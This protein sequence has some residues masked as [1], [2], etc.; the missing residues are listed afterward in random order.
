MPAALL[1][2]DDLDTHAFR[3]ATTRVYAVRQ[4]V[5]LLKLIGG[6]FWGESPEIRAFISLPPYG[7][8][9]GTRRTEA[10]VARPARTPREPSPRL[11]P[12]GRR[13][14]ER[15]RAVTRATLVHG[16]S[17]DDHPEDAEHHDLHAE[18]GA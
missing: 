14:V 18:E 6:V 9:P 11:V 10:M 13:E 3:I 2:P 5:V 8:D 12:L 7:P 4:I 17:V 16:L 15:G 1:S